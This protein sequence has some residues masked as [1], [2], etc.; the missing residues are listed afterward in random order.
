MWVSFSLFDYHVLHLLLI[1]FV[2][3]NWCCI[4]KPVR[5]HQHEEN[6]VKNQISLDL[7]MLIRCAHLFNFFTKYMGPIDSVHYECGVANKNQKTCGP[8]SF[9]HVPT[10]LYGVMVFVLLIFT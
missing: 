5:N 3:L 10:S 9:K 8:V 2:F 1:V 7:V 4:R 6:H